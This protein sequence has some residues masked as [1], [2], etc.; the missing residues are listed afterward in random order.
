MN[1]KPLDVVL[2]GA[3]NVATQL[4]MALLKNKIPVVQVYSRKIDSASALGDRLQVPYTN[5][6]AR[7]TPNAAVYIFCVKDDALLPLLKSFPKNPGLWV[8]TAGSIP[9]SVFE[10]FSDRF[11]VL[12][13]LQTFTKDRE[14]SF[15]EIPLCIEANNKAD[16]QLLLHLARKLSRNVLPLPSEKRRYYHLAAV[17][18]CNF[19][20]HL[21]ALAT[22]ILQAHQLDR[23]YLEPLI[24]ETALKIKDLSP[25]QAQTGPAVRYDRKIMD[26]HLRLLH[27]D[28]MKQKIYRLISQSIHDCAVLN[29]NSE[30]K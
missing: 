3:G 5:L 21:Y 19:T 28:T 10:D 30:I 4:G 11:G 18:A 24:L 20:N 1:V 25:Q 9:M 7:I 6:P 15:K 29:I 8:H 26:A 12:Y 17:F 16:E 22:D 13:P 2:L 23:R 27:D 14:L